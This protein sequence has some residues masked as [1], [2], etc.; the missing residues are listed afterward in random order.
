MDA[1]R[2][3]RTA[4][5]AHHIQNYQVLFSYKKW[6]KEGAS[7]RS[8]FRRICR[9]FRCKNLYLRYLVSDRQNLKKPPD[10]GRAQWITTG[11]IRLNQK[12]LYEKVGERWAAQK[13]RASSILS[14][15]FSLLFPSFGGEELQGFLSAKVSA[16]KVTGQR[17]T[18]ALFT[19][20]QNANLHPK[21][22]G[23]DARQK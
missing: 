14:C 1:Y 18:F 15:L 13:R 10:H 19:S 3:T 17:I 23:Y 4:A 20:W 8:Q 22:R 21:Q 11:N 12:F 16:K 2:K 6:R 7:K 5:R 9:F